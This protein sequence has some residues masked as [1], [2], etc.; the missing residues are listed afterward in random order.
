MKIF[1]ISDLHIGKQLH[2]YN[3]YED[4]KA[5]L[6]QI[7]D[8]AKNYRPD[9]IL[10]AGD[11]Y[12]KSVPSGEAHELFD[13]FLNNLSDIQ[14][15]IPVFIIAGNHDSAMRL[16][17]ASSFLEKH[18]IYVS[19][20]PPQ[21]E[22]EYLKRVTLEDEYGKINIYMLPFT[23]PGHVRKL[24][25]DEE[26]IIHNNA[27]KRLIDRENIDYSERNIL[28]AHQFFVSGDN[29]PEKSDSE[30]S[31]ISVGGLDSVDIKWVEKFDYVA[32]GH[33]HK[34]QHIGKKHIRY[35]G[36]PYKYSV[37]EAEHKK[38][39]TVVTIGAKGDENKYES[40]PLVADRDVRSLKGELKDVLAMANQ[41]NQE[42]YV[43][44]TLTNEE[45]INNPREILQEKYSNI[46]EIKIE[47]TRTRTQ[48]EGTDDLD[49]VLDP[50]EAFKV[51]YQEINGRPL[52]EE[53]EAVMADVIGTVQDNEGKCDR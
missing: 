50:L 39:I 34:A 40:I 20:L 6:K 47:N 36:T 30:L 1:H 37:S 17:Y 45:S 9:A 16:K 32:L 14:P 46:L 42:D 11:I 7:V 13:E 12:D 52:S 23:K 8:S 53:E 2:Y 19:V 43:S 5:V 48:F 28:V 29:E 18:K 51:F 38:A 10:I 25:E 21:N 4:Q 49:K 31:Y 44:I 33:I 26:N 27:V 15:V 24:F 3:L 35:S 22:E 41:N